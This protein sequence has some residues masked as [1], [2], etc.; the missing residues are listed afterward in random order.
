MILGHVNPMEAKW[1]PAKSD[2]SQARVAQ[3]VVRMCNPSSE[4]RKVG[5]PQQLPSHLTDLYER[6]Y[7]HLNELQK[8][9]IG[10]SCV[11]QR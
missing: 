1:A 6:S 2:N 4:A 11:L 3:E 8:L 5:A 10:A 7:T 9:L